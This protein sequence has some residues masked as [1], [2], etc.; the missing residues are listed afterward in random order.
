MYLMLGTRPDIAFAVSCLSRFMTN[1]TQ[2]HCTAI[3][4]LFR[5]LQ[6]TRDLVLVYK[7]DLKLLI[8][9]TDA[10]WGGDVAIRHSTSGYIFNI[11]SGAISW[12]SKRQPTVALSSCEAEYMG[13]T[14]AT[15]EAIWLQRLLAELHSREEKEFL[16][17]LIHGDNQGAIALSCNPYNHARTKHIDIQHHFVRE[18]QEEGEVDVQ[19]TPT[20]KQVADRLT[21]ALLKPQFIAF[22]DALGLERWTQAT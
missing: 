14:Q 16:A 9:Y 1:P 5:Y 13:Q 18:A 19:F 7:G 10:D 20:K 22:R 12:S 17:T 8:G 11:G 3:K 15:K 2:Q 21:K 6:G 4:H